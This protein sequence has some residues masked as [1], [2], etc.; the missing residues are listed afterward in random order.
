MQPSMYMRRD[1][2]HDLTQEPKESRRDRASPAKILVVPNNRSNPGFATC[3]P[4]CSPG[5]QSYR[6]FYT[7]LGRWITGRT[8][9]LRR[10]V[11]RGNRGHLGRGAQQTTPTFTPL[12]IRRAI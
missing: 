4:A 9:L 3:C 7:M 8:E 2:G 1:D 5:A 10:A 11:P 6:T 12:E